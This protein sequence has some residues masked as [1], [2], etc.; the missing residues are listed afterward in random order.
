MPEV[1]YR[2][3]VVRIKKIYSNILKIFDRI[4]NLFFVNIFSKMY[5][6]IKCVL[7]LYENSLTF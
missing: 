3:I 7:I 4:Y 5:S 6:N 1:E 2:N